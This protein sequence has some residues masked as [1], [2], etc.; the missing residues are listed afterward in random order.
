MQEIKAKDFPK[1]HTIDKYMLCT[2]KK[3]SR[4]EE[5]EEETAYHVGEY[6]REWA[7]GSASRV[8]QARKAMSNASCLEHS[9]LDL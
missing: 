3:E 6:T 8:P 1:K 9:W 7:E 2:Q 5:C 4:L